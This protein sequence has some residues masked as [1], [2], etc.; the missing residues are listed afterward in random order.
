MC[1]VAQHPAHLELRGRRALLQPLRTQ[2]FESARGDEVDDTRPNRPLP[3]P[4]CVHRILLAELRVEP[5]RE[6]RRRGSWGGRRRYTSPRPREDAVA[7]TLLRGGG[8]C[9]RPGA[10]LKVNAVAR[11]LDFEFLDDSILTIDLSRRHE[12]AT[13]AP[14]SRPLLAETAAAAAAA[15]AAVAAAAAGAALTANNLLG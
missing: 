2:R 12:K 13:A 1:R 5:C 3:A 8:H 11:R 6:V 4:R 14:L 15:A 10:R 7:V 9:W